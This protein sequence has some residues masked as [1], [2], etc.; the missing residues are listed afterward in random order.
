MC[1][2]CVGTRGFV[3]TG[4]EGSSVSLSLCEHSEVGA[5]W[6]SDV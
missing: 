5:G 3:G 4:A 6:V 1:G 2:V